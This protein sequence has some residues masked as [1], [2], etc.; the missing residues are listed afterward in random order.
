MD[1]FK[2]K[3]LITTGVR[4]AE[5][6]EA[7]LEDNEIEVIVR[8]D[9][10]GDY[11][12][13]YMGFTAYNIEIY[14]ADEN[15]DKAEKIIDSLNIEAEPEAD[16][17]A[18]TAAEQNNQNYKTFSHYLALTAKIIIIFYLLFNLAALIF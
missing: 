11:S 12:M 9:E 16:K 15:Y 7:L 1:D 10:F 5:M 3:H 14:V 6:I 17:A 18:K 2:L 8:H 4:E 13:L